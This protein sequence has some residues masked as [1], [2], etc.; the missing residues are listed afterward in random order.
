MLLARRAALGAASCL[1][2]PWGVCLLSSS[3]ASAPQPRWDNPTP[4]QL[5]PTATLGT[6]GHSCAEP[7]S[8]LQLVS[9]ESSPEGLRR[10]DSTRR[11]RNFGKQPSTGD[12]YKHLGHS[13]A[14]QPSPWRM[15]HS[16]EASPQPRAASLTG[17]TG[18]GTR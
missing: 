9:R 11:S 6:A 8:P 4:P 12:Y 15:A 16:E 14:E 3:L 13:V 18:T 5:C 1:V 7:R 17:L 10:A 2:D